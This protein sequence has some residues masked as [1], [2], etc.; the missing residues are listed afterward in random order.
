MLWGG[1]LGDS[2]LIGYNIDNKTGAVIS[3]QPAANS[4]SCQSLFSVTVPDGDHNAFVSWLTFGTDNSTDPQ[5]IH[6]STIQ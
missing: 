6:L 4:T 5:E 2:G 1:L 3:S